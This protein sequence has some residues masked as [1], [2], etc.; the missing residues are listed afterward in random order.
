MDAREFVLDESLLELEESLS[1]GTF[2]KWNEEKERLELDN[3]R[4]L[5]FL[6]DNGFGR[7]RLGDDYIYVRSVRS[8][9]KIVSPTMI[10]DFTMDHLRKINKTDVFDM[11]H[12]GSIT[13][14]SEWRLNSLEYLNIELLTDTHDTSYLFFRN[15]IVEIKADSK[16]LYPYEKL[17][18]INK[19]I[20]EKQIIDHDFTFIES[21]SPFA[22]FIRNTSSYELTDT[23][24]VQESSQGETHEPNGDRWVRNSDLKAKL[25]SLGYLLHGN[26][27]PASA[28]VIIACDSS[29]TD[30]DGKEAEGGTGK[31]LVYSNAVGRIKNT[32]QIDGKSIDL[33]DRFAFQHVGVDTQAMVFDDAGKNFNFEGLFQ[34]ITGDFTVEAKGQ[35]KFTIPFSDSPK[36]CITT[37]QPLLG[38]GNSFERR[39]H[40]IEFSDYYRFN[41]PIDVHGKIFFD[42]WNCQEWGVFYSFIIG[43]IQIFLREGL[44]KPK[45]RNYDLRKLY[46]TYSRDF[47]LWADEAIILEKEYDRD[48]L[49]KNYRE[50]AD[51]SEIKPKTFTTTLQKWC[52][53]K[54]YFFNP[55][56]NGKRDRRNGTVFIKV[57]KNHT[58]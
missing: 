40:I 49:L 6:Q 21:P 50:T 8:I 19:C 33:S 16:K 54:G 13:Y 57:S 15:C 31:S 11:M 53:F 39:Q 55:Q 51:N 41:N 2:W 34:R 24:R 14:F 30:T 23:E 27:D 18:E 47:V 45:I 48:D 5:K 37:N 10:K 3:L 20:W 12:K 26:K 44:I 56:T 58:D 32:I 35:K 22:D 28:K 52:K 9:V 36:M 4:F 42:Q 1:D 43:C 17:K 38:D 25:T 29:I 46:M 7:F